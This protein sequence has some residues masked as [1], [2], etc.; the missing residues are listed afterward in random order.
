MV[1]GRRT[2]PDERPAVE[3]KTAKNERPRPRQ[4]GVEA[5]AFFCHEG[6]QPSARDSTPSSERPYGL[7][8]PA[9][10][11][12]SHLPLR[13]GCPTGRCTPSV[14]G[15]PLQSPDRRCPERRGEMVA[16]GDGC[17]AADWLT[18]CRAMGRAAGA[19]GRVPG[20]RDPRRAA[21]PGVAVADRGADRQRVPGR[22]QGALLHPRRDPRR[23]GR[24]ERLRGGQGQ[25]DHRRARRQAVHRPRPAPALRLIPSLV[26]M[27]R[28]GAP[29][30]PAL[31]PPPAAGA[32]R[33]PRRRRRRRRAGRRFPPP[34]WAATAPPCR[35]AR[36]RCRAPAWPG[37]TAA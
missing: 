27:R 10:G 33:S 30:A 35:A 17:M 11:T 15:G 1:Q 13:A 7:R 32:G 6:R 3:S 4:R 24:R 36:G 28:K 5:P 21:A 12:G 29:R 14:Q 2:G 37:G 26:G 23:P 16:G 9:R 34:P 31:R 19:G 22:G 8:G 20:L 18:I 25:A